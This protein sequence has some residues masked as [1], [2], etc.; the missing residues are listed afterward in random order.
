MFSLFLFS[1]IILLDQTGGDDMICHVLVE[2]TSKKVDKTFTYLIPKRFQT[3]L[4]VGMRV[5]VP[6]G[7]RQLEGFVL[8]IE[9]KSEKLDYVLKEIID[10]IDLEPILN[11]EML[12][13]GKY[14]SKTTLSTLM[15]AYQTMLPVAMKAKSKCVVSKKYETY[16]R[17][18]DFDFVAS[19][20]SQKKILDL[21]KKCDEILK[22]EAS[23]I[24]SSSLKTL[25]GKGVIQELEREVYRKVT[26]GEQV[27]ERPILNTEQESVIRSIL[28]SKDYFQ[29]FL[30]HGVTGSGKT[31]VYMRVIEEVLKDQKEA[32]LL[33]PEISLTPQIIATFQKRFGD[34]IAILHSR[35]SDGEKYDEWRRIERKEVS[36][37]IGARSAIF[38]PFT[39]LGVII[40]DEEHSNTYKQENN[41]RYHASMM[42]LWR[43][44]RHCCPVLFGSA[45]P[46]IESY[47]W[48]KMGRYRLLEMK[49][50]V[51]SCLPQV[52]LIDMKQSIRQGNRILSLPLQNSIMERLKRQE[53]VILL[54]NRRGYEVILTCQDCGY[55]DECPNCDIPL[56]YHKDR[57]L[58]ECHYCNYSH[59]K[60]TVCPKC[61][62]HSMNGFGLGT[63]KLEHVV[64]E[65][66]PMARVV[67]MDV[68]TTR[69][70]GS[71]E[72]IIASFGR[73]EYDI[74][75]GTQMIAKGLDFPLVTLVGVIN[76]DSTLNIPDFR[77]AE[78]TFDLL[79][80]VAGR[81]GRGQLSG[82]VFIQSFNIDHYSIQCAAE[83]NYLSFYKQ[84][85][86]IRKKLKY[87]PYFHLCL[88]RMSGRNMN[89]LEMESNK[90]Q[91][92]L[93]NHITGAMILGPSMANMPKVNQTYYM[94]IILKYQK[95]SD[96]F[97]AV[98]FIE[99]KYRS[100]SKVRVDVDF[101]P[102]KI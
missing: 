53:Q 6:F 51:N 25:I 58:M 92:Y 75:I 32:I 89:E 46:S 67:R 13:L 93:K 23:S 73:H 41:P 68:D 28:D 12:E 44:K 38:A 48:A 74:M 27:N 65:L 97:E 37:V 45:T 9:Q 87:P 94:N 56:T 34:Q 96:I 19:N 17:L 33:V 77:S 39:N 7:S 35:L 50:R 2:I 66:F 24:S 59:P 76:G 30:L 98:S 3:M 42:A 84:E 91:S 61:R 54:L 69:L 99:Q 90:I 1:G 79:N 8:K 102:L 82:E 47:T 80:Q 14:L 18:V 43:G 31:E 10:V 49:N 22:K 4:Q 88:L 60:V 29:P 57:N 95:L 72:K 62:S 26:Q 40:I 21:F 85:M 63:E 86:N 16:L 100:V 20:G 11:E 78:R 36:I 15:S 81:A 52:K 55:T 83:H 101:Q 64:S 5:L 70:K 71:H